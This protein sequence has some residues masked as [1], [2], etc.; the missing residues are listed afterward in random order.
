M[1]ETVCKDF[2]AELNKWPK[3]KG[4]G[5]AQPPQGGAQRAEPETPTQKLQNFIELFPEDAEETRKDFHAELRRKLAGLAPD[6]LCMLWEG[7]TVLRFYG[8]KMLRT[9][10]SVF[11]EV[12]V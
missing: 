1:S 10:E 2:H 8:S 9:P 6:N 11:E 7:S 12:G 5:V 4:R 3:A